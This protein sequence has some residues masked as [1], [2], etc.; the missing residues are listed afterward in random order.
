MS[1]RVIPRA[2]VALLFI[3]PAQRLDIIC[4]N[5]TFFCVNGPIG[6]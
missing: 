5:A 6:D 1:I 3:Q 4:V 2:Y